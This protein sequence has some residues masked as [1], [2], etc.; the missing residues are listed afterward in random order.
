MSLP[1][2]GRQT[3]SPKILKKEKK[4]K[5]KRQKILTK[6][7]HQPTKQACNKQHTE[8][9]YTYLKVKEKDQC[10]QNNLKC[11]RI[12]TQALKTYTQGKEK[13]P[14]SSKKNEKKKL[15]KPKVLTITLI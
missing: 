7:K 13:N 9:A 15:P 5:E 10:R 8:N 4:D 11:K 6:K 2:G 14:E 3:T 12:K 1:K